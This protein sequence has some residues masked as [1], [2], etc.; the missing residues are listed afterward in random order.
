MALVN[1][2]AELGGGGEIYHYWE[3][4]FLK[5]ERETI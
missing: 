5:N 1:G 4:N 2:E 3:E